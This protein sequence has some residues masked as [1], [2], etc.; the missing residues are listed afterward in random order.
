MSSLQGFLG[1]DDGKQA[2][3]SFADTAQSIR[4]LAENLDKR[5]AEMAASFNR[6]AGTGTRDLDVLTAEARRTLSEINRTL[7]DFNRNPQ[8]IIFGSRPGIPEYNRS[9]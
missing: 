5:T 1:S 9:R 8:Q 3:A 7:G 2:A 4:K 6:V